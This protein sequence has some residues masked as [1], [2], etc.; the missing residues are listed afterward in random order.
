ML[1][2]IFFSF[3]SIDTQKAQKLKLFEKKSELKTFF[4]IFDFQIKVCLLCANT[5]WL[6]SI[7]Y[8]YKEKYS[9]VGYVLTCI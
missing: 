6:F 1:Y 7:G 3:R 8:M 9:N 2:I 4:E 5:I